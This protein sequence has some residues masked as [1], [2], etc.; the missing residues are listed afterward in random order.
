[1]AEYILPDLDSMLQELLL[2]EEGEHEFTPQDGISDLRQLFFP[3]T[4]HGVY[5]NHASQGPMPRPVAV[6]M[7]Q[8]VD[9]VSG[10]GS[11][12]VSLWLEYIL[13]ARRRLA[14]MINGHPSQI[15]FTGSTGDGLMLLASA[16]TWQE[17]D[18]I[19]LAE[20]EFPSNVYPWLSLQEQ[21][22]KV[23]FV[24]AY[25]NRISAD[26]VKARITDRTRLVSLSLVEF[27]TGFRND[28]QSIASYCHERG[29]LCGIDAMQALGSIDVDVQALDVDFLVGSSHKWLLAP[30]R[31]GLLYVSTDFFSKLQ[32]R[33]K[34]WFSVEEPYDFFNYEQP[35]KRGAWRF[36]HSFPNIMP[37]VGLDSALGLFDGV[38]GGIQAVEQRIL[39]L[40]EYALDGLEHLGYP[41][42]TPRGKGERSGIVTF[43]LHPARPD[44]TVPQAVEALAERSITVSARGNG[45]RISPHFYNTLQDLDQLLNALE[46]LKQPPTPKK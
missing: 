22:V 28:I 19:L 9:D 33:R 45:V 29:V 32:M 21:G 30:Q 4:R 43:Q 18:T 3:V 2:I 37:I 39:G 5:L 23:E 31:T 26:E 11:A 34:S 16:L 6:T 17:G 35:L 36:E 44:L 13:G 46:D 25:E 8:Y 38:E 7:H 27:L 12:H 10:F 14:L 20:G 15:A 1:M 41:L 40:T 42:I 24:P